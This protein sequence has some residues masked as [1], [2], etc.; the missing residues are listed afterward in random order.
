MKVER[1]RGHHR[2][3]AQEHENYTATVKAVCGSG[4]P[5][6]H[7]FMLVVGALVRKIGIPA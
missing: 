1:P 7:A 6:Q 4:M 3:D 5:H 2:R